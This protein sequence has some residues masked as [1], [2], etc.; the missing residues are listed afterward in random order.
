MK[1]IIFAF[2]L[3]FTS[4]SFSQSYSCDR[5]SLKR[6]RITSNTLPNAYT[7]YM[8]LQRG[9]GMPRLATGFLIHPRVVLT[10]GHNVA[11]YPNGSVKKVDMYFGSLDSV[12][13]L[14]KETIKLKKN[15]NKFYKGNYYIFDN[16][17]RDYAIVILPDSAVYKKVKGHYKIK[18]IRQVK[19][20]SLTITGA[21]KD[22]PKFE[23]WTETTTNYQQFNSFLKYDLYTLPR[24]SGSPIWYKEDNEYHIIGVHSRKYGSCG[25]SVLIT[26]KIYKQIKKW[27]KKA[28]IDL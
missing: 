4:L 10:A 20:D 8:E 27:C 22:K 5:D 18:P 16:I 24:N 13:Y 6:V 7:C 3:F 19:V 26:P 14:A 1:S 12:T 15:K 17:K 23:M 2:L 11:W 9:N 25:A 28:G 21:P